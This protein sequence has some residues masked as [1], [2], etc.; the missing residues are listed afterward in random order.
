MYARIFQIK[1]YAQ[2]HFDVNYKSLD[3]VSTR[4]AR[5]LGG[6][7]SVAEVKFLSS[8]ANLLAS[9]DFKIAY[10]CTKKNGAIEE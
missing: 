3:V 1:F 7:R 6:N 2:V 4:S 8:I 5:L 10:V 9:I